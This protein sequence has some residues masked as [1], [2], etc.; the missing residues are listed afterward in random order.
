M[1]LSLQVPDDFCLDKW[2]ET[3]LPEDVALGLNAIPQLI[4]FV[5]S[6]N[7]NDHLQI[8]ELDELKCKNQQDKIRELEEENHKLASET[9]RVKSDQEYSDPTGEHGVSVFESCSNGSGHFSSSM[10]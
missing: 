5:N 1:H 4:Q 7:H 9:A 8:K 3:A 6:K 10:S 2:F